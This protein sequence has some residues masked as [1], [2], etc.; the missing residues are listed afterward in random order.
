MIRVLLVI[1]TELIGNVI[2]SVLED[3]PDIEVAGCVTGFAE[4]LPYVDRTA[5]DVVL[6]STRLS[7]GGALEL[8]RRL[9]ERD[10]QIK[11]L[12]LGLD[13]HKQ[14]V[15]QYVEAGA[16]GYIRDDHSVD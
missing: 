11:V 10:S 4:A 14:R 7:D 9:T 13:E 6:V 2:T 8:T 16:S 15:L 1:E 3:E 5:V 12:A